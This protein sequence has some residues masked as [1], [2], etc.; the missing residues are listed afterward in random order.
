MPLIRRAIAERKSYSVIAHDFNEQGVRPPRKTP[1]TKNAIWRTFRLVSD[2]DGPKRE[3]AA[4]ERKGAAQVK[5]SL[6]LNE[7]GPLLLAWR[8]EG[9]AYAWMTSELNR[10]GIKSPWQRS[11]G[12]ASLRRY[13]LRA[14][15][16]MALP[17]AP[18]SST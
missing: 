8:S 5:V 10:R 9:K 7:V 11:W 2:E 3:Q 1:W 17:S 14:M 12:P 16:V 6:L 13:L 15:D 4:V 18:G